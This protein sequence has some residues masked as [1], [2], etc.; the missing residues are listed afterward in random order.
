MN[1]G[2]ENNIQFL[3]ERFFMLIDPQNF[4]QM[5]LRGFSGVHM[6]IFFIIITRMTTSI[7]SEAT[8]QW[9]KNLIKYMLIGQRNNHKQN[10]T[11][12]LIG[13]R[14]IHVFVLYTDLTT[15]KM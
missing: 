6:T 13:S 3:K 12:I 8:D 2:V 7:R 10:S 1:Q 9:K 4:E 15:G 5:Y 14:E 11:P